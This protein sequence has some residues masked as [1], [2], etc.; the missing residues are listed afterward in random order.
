MKPEKL[1]FPLM[2]FAAVITVYLLFKK[3]PAQQVLQPSTAPSGV[4]TYSTEGPN[5]YNVQAPQAVG[6]PLVYLADPWSDNPLGDV[7]KK[8]PAY[9]AFNFGPSHDLTKIPSSGLHALQKAASGKCGSGCGGC[10]SCKQDVN[11]FPDGSSDVK[12]ASTNVRQADNAP[13]SFLQIAAL[14]LDLPQ[15]QAFAPTP[16]TPKAVAKSNMETVRTGTPTVH[17]FDIGGTLPQWAT[18]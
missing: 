17:A 6:S 7:R 5:S 8:P 18:L 10:N 9:L 4:P 14:N 12:L 3:Q 13:V 15:D 11:V 1:F 16:S 2:V